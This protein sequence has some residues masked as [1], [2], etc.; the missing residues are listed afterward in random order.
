MKKLLPDF[1]EGKSLSEM[2]KIADFYHVE[3]ADLI[4]KPEIID[5]FFL[6]HNEVGEEDF[7]SLSQFGRVIVNYNRLQRLIKEL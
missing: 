3:L 1:L 4:D 6:K 7:K 2:E 5:K